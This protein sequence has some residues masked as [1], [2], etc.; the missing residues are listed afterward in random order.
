MAGVTIILAR[1]ATELAAW[2]GSWPLRSY[3]SR[4]VCDD[5]C[6]MRVVCVCF[7]GLLSQF[8]STGAVYVVSFGIVGV[9][10][11]RYGVYP[12]C[13]VFLVLARNKEA[14]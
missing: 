2:P 11:T 3:C 6:M 13:I 14:R 7:V 9:L 10:T 1:A 8:V 12:L 4:N 5:L